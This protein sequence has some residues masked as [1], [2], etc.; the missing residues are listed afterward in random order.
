MK[1]TKW[2]HT[3]VKV[4]CRIIQVFS[5][6]Y[7]HTTISLKDYSKNNNGYM[8]ILSL[9]LE[10]SVIVYLV[11]QQYFPKQQS[12]LNKKQPSMNNI[13][14]DSVKNHLPKGYSRLRKQYMKNISCYRKTSHVLG[15]TCFMW[16]E[17]IFSLFCCCCPCSLF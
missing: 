14:Y 5:N 13:G 2:V 1:R 11:L 17:F 10:I 6:Y 9:L 4:R 3:K 15:Q 8:F 16:A 7:H 12:E